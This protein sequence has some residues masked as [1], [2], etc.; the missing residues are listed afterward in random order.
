M[1]R[2]AY[3]NG[4]YVPHDTAKVH[5]EDRG[6]QFGDGVY[7]VIA[8]CGGHLV[9]ADRHLS[10]LWRSLDALSISHPVTEATLRIILRVMAQKNR[11]KDG[12]IYL[13]V[14]RGA[15]PRD[16][17][18][19]DDAKP[20]LVVTAR[21]GLWSS[22]AK[23]EVGA[24]VITYP[25]QRW[26]RRDIKTICLLPS[27]L[28]KQAAVDAGAFEAWMLDPDGFITEGSSST[29][30][31]VTADG[32]L[33]TRPFTQ[34]VLPGV[35]RLAVQDIAA[36]HGLGF[37]ERAFTV[38]EAK[39]SREAFMT[40][41]TKFIMPVVRIDDSIVGSGKPGKTSQALRTAYINAMM[42]LRSK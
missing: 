31:I 24:S 25:D 36:E 30:W 26:A 3:V 21:S 33:V 16:F 29:A 17:P 18:F 38:A 42:D 19:P 8:L 34:T 12:Q 7:E 10:R 15:A 32:V 13:Q 4:R 40:S 11:L 20:T 23:A 27:V 37:E 39:A 6:Y 2:I 1:P 14:T 9:D 28:A 5:V 41:A 35:T 22:N